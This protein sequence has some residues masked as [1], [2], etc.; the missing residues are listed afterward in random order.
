M[1][2]SPDDDGRHARGEGPGA[3]ARAREVFT[4]RAVEQFQSALDRIG[5]VLGVD[6]AGI[7][8]ID[9]N[10]P[11]ILVARPDR[12]GQRIEQGLHGLDVGQKPVVT[13][14]EVHQFGFDAADVAQ[15]QHRAPGDRAS[16]RLERP[17]GA[18][19]ERHHE[20]AALLAQGLDRV[21]HAL[22]RRR[23]QP[24]A[25]GEHA[26]RHRT[27]YRDAGIADD[28]RLV[29]ARRPGHQNLRLRQQQHLVMVEFGAQQRGFVMRRGLRDGGGLARAQEHDDGQHR[30][31]EQAE[32][33]GG[34][35][36]LLT[37]CQ[38]DEVDDAVEN[39]R[40]GMA[41]APQSD[42]IT[43][44]RRNPTHRGRERSLSFAVRIVS[45][46]FRSA[47]GMRA[48]A[49]APSRIKGLYRCGD[50]C[51]KSPDREREPQRTR[52]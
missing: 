34:G 25:E 5:R 17:A 33:H 10:Q 30:K 7:G 42:V 21:L 31:A 32:R 44:A 45:G 8:R 15:P 27:R 16:F 40:A 4:R 41:G 35:G 1:R 37:V 28:F 20:A 22:R 19:G 50:S 2:R 38:V 26:L 51:R 13:G 48:A 52:S 18:G 14:G 36:N 6:G 11:A 39:A 43:K 23:F 3:D 12:T 46:I 47:P 9:E 49:A 29:G 24:G